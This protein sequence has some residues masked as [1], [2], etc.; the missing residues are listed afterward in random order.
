M[1]SE[2]EKL[3]RALVVRGEP[4]GR[5]GGLHLA[6]ADRPSLGLDGTVDE[7]HT[8]GLGDLFGQVRG[9]LLAGNRT[10]F[11]GFVELLFRPLSKPRP[12]AIIGAEGVAAGEDEAAGCELS[13]GA[14]RNK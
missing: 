4:F 9:P 1:L 7:E 10:D 14:T 13:H 8:V 3:C 5:R 12:Y 2:S 6:K 11:W